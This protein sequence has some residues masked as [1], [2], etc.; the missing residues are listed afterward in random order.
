[1]KIKE[2]EEIKYKWFDLDDLAH[3]GLNHHFDAAH[4]FIG[5][6]IMIG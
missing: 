4:E 3:V 1:M 5:S 6:F 2:Y